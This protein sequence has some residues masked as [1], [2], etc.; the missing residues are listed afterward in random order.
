MLTGLPAWTDV[1]GGLAGEVEV[2]RGAGSLVVA[3]PGDSQKELACAV[4][5]PGF[6]RAVA[7]LGAGFER[8]GGGG[9]DLLGLADLVEAEED[10]GH[11]VYARRHGE[12]VTAG[13]GD[14]C[15]AVGCDPG[16]SPSP[17]LAIIAAVT[18]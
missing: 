17:S 16:V 4:E 14:C 2:M 3:R 11:P 8:C 12:G 10:M 18:W 15:G 5:R 1:L 7:G 6:G 9:R 13:F